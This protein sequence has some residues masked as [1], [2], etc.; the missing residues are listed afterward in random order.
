[1]LATRPLLIHCVHLTASDVR[2]IVDAGAIVAHCPTANARLGHGVAPAIE[3]LEAGVILGLGS[4]S[5]AA[6]NR[7]DLL[8][9][10]RTAQLMQRAR[11]R[12]ASALPPERLLRLLTIDGARALRM[13]A[14]V[15]SLEV[16]K[17]ADLCAVRLT[18]PHARPVADPVATLVLST[19]GTDVALTVAAGSV[20]YR[21]GRFPTLS[22]DALRVRIDE[23][24][25]R[26]HAARHRHT[27]A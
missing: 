6:N 1:M 26:L 14:R 12:S 9:E 24:G 19:R 10:A 22:A 3:L 27:D 21:D 4:D 18:A 25:V 16:G 5:V 8:E 7:V 11:L 15:G 17:D 20:L 2:A 23:L 13:D